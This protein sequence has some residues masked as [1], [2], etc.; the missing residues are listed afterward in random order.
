MLRLR[1]DPSIILMRWLNSSVL[2]CLAIDHALPVG[3]VVGASRV[4]LIPGA[5]RKTQDWVC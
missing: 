1:G 3:W 2:G 4:S 5:V